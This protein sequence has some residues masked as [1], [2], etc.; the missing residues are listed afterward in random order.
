M[1]FHILSFLLIIS[2]ISSAQIPKV[3]EGKIIRLEQFNST[4]TNARNIDIWLPKDY[5]NSDE[6]YAVLYMHD[7]QML[8]DSS[9][10]WNKQS[11]DVDDMAS[12]LFEKENITKFIVVGIWNDGQN[13]HADYFPQKPYEILNKAEKKYCSKQLTEKGRIL[14]EFKPNSDNYLKFIVQELKPYIDKNFKTKIDPNNT[15]IA[16]S[17]MGGLISL[18]ALCEYPNIFGGA[19][20][21]STHW[22]GI[23]SIKHNPIPKVFYQYLSKNLPNPTQHKLYFDSGDQTLD[24]LYPSLQKK[25]DGIMKKKGYSEKNWMTKFFPGDNHSENAWKN[26][27]NF[28]LLFLFGK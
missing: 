7:G 10:A 28:P 9:I 6:K 14:H 21:L 15:Y 24:A 3:V 27:L 4:Y 8:L 20:C 2:V 1:K 18:Y 12:T 26:R 5:E 16:G 17:S 13:R 23:F 22:P 11:W 25:V 19:A